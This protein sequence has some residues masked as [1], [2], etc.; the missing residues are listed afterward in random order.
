MARK[1]GHY[2]VWYR[3]A[4]TVRPDNHFLPFPDTI[5]AATHCSSL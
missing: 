4:V 3:S 1:L 5:Y 2:W